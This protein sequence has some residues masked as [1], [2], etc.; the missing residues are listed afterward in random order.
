VHVQPPWEKGDLAVLFDPK[1]PIFAKTLLE[2]AAAFR[3]EPP[4]R[5]GGLMMAFTL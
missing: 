3:F 5:R 2:G 4:D 1:P